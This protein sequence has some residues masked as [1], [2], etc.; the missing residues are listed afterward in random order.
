MPGLKK[1]RQIFAFILHCT[2][3]WRV[4]NFTLHF[5][6]IMVPHKFPVTIALLMTLFSITSCY[7]VRS[8]LGPTCQAGLNDEDGFWKDKQFTDTVVRIKPGQKPVMNINC[9]AKCVCAIEYKV[10]FGNVL[11]TGITLGFVRRVKV[12]YACCQPQHN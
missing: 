3:S 1:S 2:V 12:R 10:G 9:P 4:K 8:S 7:T 11:V 6:Y 5:F